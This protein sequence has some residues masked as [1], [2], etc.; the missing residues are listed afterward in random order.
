MKTFGSSKESVG[1]GRGGCGTFQTRAEERSRGIEAEFRLATIEQCS[2]AMM[3]LVM[4]PS[5]LL[6]LRL[7]S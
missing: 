1:V 6:D 5:W 7:K 3:K 4:N 2:L